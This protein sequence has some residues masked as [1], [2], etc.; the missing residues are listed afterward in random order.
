MKCPAPSRCRNPRLPCRRSWSPLSPPS[1]DSWTYPRIVLSSHPPRPSPAR[2]PRPCRKRRLLRICSRRAAW[3]GRPLHG[4]RGSL[5]PL[6]LS[7][8]RCPLL[9]RQCRQHPL[10]RRLRVRRPLLSRRAL[11]SR[12]RRARRSSSHSGRRIDRRMC[13]R[14]RTWPCRL[15]ATARRLRRSSHRTRRR[16][17]SSHPMMASNRWRSVPFLRL[18]LKRYP[19]RKTRL[20]SPSQERSTARLR[21]GASGCGG[22]S[23]HP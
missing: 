6:S 18:W 15:K 4:W 10:P 2:L 1:L 17:K 21:R 20:H 7:R 8:S 11:F 3:I 22:R 9:Q 14:D 12:C 16:R 13:K 5:A 23:G 19:M